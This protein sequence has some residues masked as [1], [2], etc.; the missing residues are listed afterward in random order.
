[1]LARARFLASVPEGQ[2]EAA[3]RIFVRKDLLHRDPD[4][5]T[6]VWLAEQTRNVALSQVV[7][8]GR[9]VTEGYVEVSSGLKQGD[10]LIADAPPDLRDG[11]RIR[12]IA[13]DS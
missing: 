10:R 1:M 4:G 5:G 11:Q 13:E 9:A 12:I 8:P 3:R 7:V 6:R 2:P